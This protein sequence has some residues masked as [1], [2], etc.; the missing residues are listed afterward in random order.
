MLFSSVFMQF[1]IGLTLADQLSATFDVTYH[2]V[3]IYFCIQYFNKVNAV[4]R[5]LFLMSEKNFYG[6]YYY[7]NRP[8]ASVKTKSNPSEVQKALK[9]SKFF[10]TIHSFLPRLRNFILR[11]I[12]FEF[13]S[14]PTFLWSSLSDWIQQ[15]K[16]ILWWSC[17]TAFA[18]CSGHR[19]Q[20]RA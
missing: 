17:Q 11:L 16:N 5:S 7:P 9:K 12:N 18:T 4:M 2:F 8:P 15:K 20:S 1:L 3:Y 13:I 19:I 6:C 14:A 10:C